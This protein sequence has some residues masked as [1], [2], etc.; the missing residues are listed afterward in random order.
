MQQV[1]QESDEDSEGEGPKERHY[2]RA[3]KAVRVVSQR[4]VD[5]A[6]INKCVH[7]P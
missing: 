4:E 5:L 7:S 1:M 6:R 2:L 3:E